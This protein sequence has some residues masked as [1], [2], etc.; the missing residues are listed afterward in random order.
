[1]AELIEA[2][3]WTLYTLSLSKRGCSLPPFFFDDIKYAVVAMIR[4]SIAAAPAI[5]PTFR[6]SPAVS[7]VES[8]TAAGLADR[9]CSCVDRVVV[10]GNTNS[11]TNL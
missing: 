11:G 1:M 9:A 7:V 2:V 3:S 5:M 6:S 4:T 10:V 8:S